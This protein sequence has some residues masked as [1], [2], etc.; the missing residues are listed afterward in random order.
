MFVHVL[1]VI[2]NFYAWRF[3]FSPG[4]GTLVAYCGA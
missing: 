4:E 2:G 1:G 3:L